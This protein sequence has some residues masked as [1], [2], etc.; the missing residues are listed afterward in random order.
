SFRPNTVGR[1]CMDLTA[2]DVTGHDVRAGDSVELFGT[3]ITL[4]EVAHAAG[5]LPYELLARIHERVVRI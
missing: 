1:I 4:Q 5:T 2:I 3:T